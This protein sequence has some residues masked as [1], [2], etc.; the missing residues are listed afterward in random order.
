MA[1]EHQSRQRQEIK[2]N[3]AKL[4]ATENLIVEHRNDIPTASFD[5]DRRVLQLP[6]WDK[7][8]GV[9]Y[10]MLVG[11][12]VGHALYTPNEDYTDYVQCPQD[13]VNVVEDVRIEKFMKRKYPGLR[14]SFAGGYKELNDQD[15]FQIEG[16]N[17]AGLILIDRINLHYKVGPTALIP[18]SDSELGFVARVEQTETFE[19]V[20]ALADEIYQ[21]TKAENERKQKEA[22]VPNLSGLELDGESEDG[23]KEDSNSLEQPSQPGEG[24]GDEEDPKVDQD[25][26]TSSGGSTTGGSTPGNEGG[27]EGA[28]ES[29]TQRSFDGSASQLSSSGGYNIK[30]FE[31]PDSVDLDDYLVDWVEVHDWIDSRFAQA[32]SPK[33]SMGEDGSVYWKQTGLEDADSEYASHRKE[34]QKE[35]NYLVKEFEC[36]KSADA[37]ARATTAKTGVLDCSKLHTYKYNEDLFKKVTV[38]PD[39]KN[40]GLIFLLD[41]S[42]SMADQLH[43]TFKQLL[44]LTAFCKKVQIP[45]EVYAFTNEWRIVDLIR[46]NDPEAHSYYYHDRNTTPPE[47]GEFHLPKGE[48]HL[49]NILSSRSNSRDYERQC[50]NI[51]RITW[52]YNGNR[53]T[54]YQIP[55]GMNLSGTPL[56]EAV[57][58]LNY[59]IPKFKQAND[60]QKVN[61]VIL[62]DGEA[63]CSGY[64]RQTDREGREPRVFPSKIGYGNALRDRKTGIVYKPLTNSYVGLTNQLLNQVR[65][66]NTGVNVIGFRIMSGSRL[67]EFV[68]RY[69]KLGSNYSQIQSEW[70]KHKSVIVPNPLGYSALYAIQQTA[71]DNTTEFDVESGSKKADISRAFKK[72]LKS[73][74]SNKKLL[75]SFIGYVA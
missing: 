4:L 74:S 44:N 40:H 14:K 36:R 29:K 1:F 53:G 35:V 59:I 9:V 32:P 48:L 33:I 18:F 26:E 68:C 15:F 49:L 34:A 57:V 58:M 24:E 75:N 45:F 60:L 17:I 19:E 55:E 70:R 69:S 62:T 3:L 41:W 54:C 56:N 10:D 31:I 39:G 13:Y 20:C 23:E 28:E 50:R 27:Q 73:K 47:L 25:Y 63:C 46:S 2:G 5:V 52:S 71:L 11:H 6:Q 30:Y 65:D 12:E 8:S 42:G 43:A 67:Q 64:G 16:E 51:W 66:R 21:Y 37:Y 7:A 72:M 22:D 61:A 38:V